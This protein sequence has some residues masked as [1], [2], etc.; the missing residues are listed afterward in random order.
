MNDYKVS[1]YGIFSDAVGTTNKLNEGLDLA[2]DIVKDCKSQLNN[3]AI[4]MGPTSEQAVE[5]CNKG[6]S[7]IELLSENYNAIGNY[8]INTSSNYKAG[9]NQAKVTVL[10]IGSSGK[11]GTASQSSTANFSGS[12]NQEKLYSYLSSQ[13]FNNAAICGILANIQHES[14]FDTT[15]LGDN[16]TS[17]GI[18]QWHAG[19]WD[20]LKSYCSKNNLDADSLEGQAKYLVSELKNSYPDVYNTLKNVPNTPQGAYDAAYKWT[21]DFEIPADK[22]SQGAGRGNTAQTTYWNKY[23]NK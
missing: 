19:R 8:L 2:K 16:G 5:A 14:G 10:S 21:V 22:Y 9:D 17:Y 11:V 18:C 7:N 15:A 3:E 13:G 6:C 1:D 12:N 23:G 20:S 4:F